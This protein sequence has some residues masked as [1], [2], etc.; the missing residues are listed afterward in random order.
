M[1]RAGDPDALADAKAVNVFS[2]WS[3]RPVARRIEF[4]QPKRPSS[5]QIDAVETP[6]NLQCQRQPAGPPG[7]IQKPGGLAVHPHL[8]E[9]FERLQRADEHSASYVWRLGSDIQHEMIAVGEV[10]VGMAA[11]QEHGANPRGRPPKMMRSGIPRRISF[12][13]DDSADQPPGGQLSHHYLADKEA[14]QRHRPDGQ[15]GPAET[16]NQD[17]TIVAI[18]DAQRLSLNRPQIK[19]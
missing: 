19:F 1:R 7:Q 14:R 17:V 16:A 6:V 9:A 8:I 2:D 10:D 3:E 13:F 4:A 18:Y 12:G 11:A 15:L 5:T